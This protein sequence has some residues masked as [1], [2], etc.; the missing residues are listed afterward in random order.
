MNDSSPTQNPS[1]AS[2]AV[3]ETGQINNQKYGFEAELRT[4]RSWRKRIKAG[5]GSVL[6]ASYTIKLL[7]HW[8]DLRVWRNAHLTEATPVY[9][10]RYA[11][12]DALIAKELPENF[13]YLEFGCASG[14]VVRRWAAAVPSSESR[15]YGFDT[16]T[17]MPEEWRGL[18]WRVDKGAWS[19]N[20]EMPQEE[21]TRITY[22]QG[23]FQ[24][25]LPGFLKD[26]QVLER[27]DHFVVHID[28]DLY[29]A[30]L[31]VLTMLHPI[32]DRATVLFDEFDCQL[33]EMKAL[34]DYCRAYAMTY[35][36]LATADACEKLAIRFQ[37]PNQSKTQ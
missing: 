34:E 16:F 9:A 18:G 3:S 15:F 7:A 20:G 2:L 32:M 19:Q 29:S 24:D 8:A 33:D 27:F 11:L 31:Y 6:P 14:A 22:I 35:K 4:P 10:S 23:R 1:Q 26:S 17:G 37:K 30:A 21:D 28:A 36:V 5:L 13:A 12:Y 25:S